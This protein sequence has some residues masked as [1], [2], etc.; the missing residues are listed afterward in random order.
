MRFGGFGGRGGAVLPM[1]PLWGGK[2]A[3]GGQSGVLTLIL[4][5][6]GL[7]GKS[8]RDNTQ[9]G[10]YNSFP[11]MNPHPASPTQAAKLKQSRIFLFRE[12][13]ANAP[14]PKEKSHAA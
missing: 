5:F 1:V 13:R 10:S 3:P 11:E 4:S 9:G 6:P 14:I 8:K 2:P 12:R 7:E